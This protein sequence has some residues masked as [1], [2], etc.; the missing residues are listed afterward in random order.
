MGIYNGDEEDIGVDPVDASHAGGYTAVEDVEL[1]AV[2]DI[3]EVALDRFGSAWNVPEEDRY[4]DHEMMLTSEDPDIVSVCTPSILHCEHVEDAARLGDL[5]VIWCEKPIAC[6]VSDAESMVEICDEE[7]VELVI[8][9]SQRFIRQNQ[10]VKAAVDDGLIGDIESVTAGSSMELL[11]VGTHV[12]DYVVHLMDGRANTVAGHVTGENQAAEHLTSDHVDDA[13]AGGFVVLEDGT[14]VTFD[15]TGRRGVSTFHYR[16]NG[17]DGRLVNAEDGWRY[18]AAT[19]DGHE[20]RDP[21]T[22][23]YED[24][25]EQSFANAV[26]HIV[27]LIE[28]R[29]ENRSPGWQA[30]H[31]L[32]ILVGFYIADSTGGR[33]SVPLDRPLKDVTVTSW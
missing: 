6:S 14:F 9:H 16:I 33:V 17:A 12:V 8:N 27:D 19:D 29:T 26:T 4:T 18:W 15:G 23:R 30:C 21:P 13:G 1:T 5:D 10:S 7:D 11:R 28:G 24:D 2:A 20:E 32:E 22:D 31:T 3:D 25:H